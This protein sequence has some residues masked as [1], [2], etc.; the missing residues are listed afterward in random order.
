VAVE[1]APRLG[2]RAGE[3]R[4][5]DAGVQPRRAR[6][7]LIWATLGGLL[8]GFEIFVLAKWITG[9]N[10]TT[11][12][13]GPDH[14]SGA[15]HAMYVAIQIAVPLATALVVY[16]C[17]IR[18][19]RREGRMTTDG[20]IA[21]SCGLLFFWDMCMNYTSV[22]LLYNSNL[23]NVGAWA[24]GSW[25]G[26]TSH[27]ANLLPEPLLV[28]LP[29]YT[30]MC[31]TQVLLVLWVLRRVKA[32]YPQMGVLGTLACIFVGL[33]IIDTII[34]TILL[35]L[36]V[37]AYPGGIRAITLYAGHTYQLPMS[38]PVFFAGLGLGAAA[39][40]SHFRDDHGRTLVERGLDRV[41]VSGRRRQGVKFLA[42]FGWIHLAFLV[43]YM[44]PNQWLA[45]HAGPFPKGY[46]SYMINGMCD[47]PGGHAVLQTR[48]IPGVPCPGP[49]VS[50]PRPTSTL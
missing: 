4:D 30:C 44:I 3:D 5:V 17:V 39:V 20:M 32:R 1:S 41:N 36:G 12:K 14:V 27:N 50:I 23:L 19:W 13:P 45:T 6:P 25:L 16:L 46:K 8:L 42:I 28:C 22:S 9:P 49:G 47:Y 11:T 18:P 37:Y 38:E 40:L 48:E 21:V 26:W 2:I 43:M 29:G 7:V 15:T 10:L 31:F 34:E 24:S 35:R 33:T